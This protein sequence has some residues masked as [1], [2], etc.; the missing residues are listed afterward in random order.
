MAV[1]LPLD[2]S[3]HAGGRLTCRDT[4]MEL[5]SHHRPVPQYRVLFQLIAPWGTQLLA[6]LTLALI[7]A[8]LFLLWPIPYLGYTTDPATNIID[9]IDT[10]STASRAG[11]AVGD[12]ILRRY[13]YD[14]ADTGAQLFRFPL[15]WGRVTGIP[16]VIERDGVVRDLVL[17]V[18]PPTAAY[19]VEKLSAFGVGIIC[20][21]AGCVL[22][23]S[24]RPLPLRLTLVAWFWLA[25]GAI[26]GFYTFASYSSYPLT[27]AAQWLLLTI[28]APVSVYIHVWYPARPVAPATR[29]AAGR[30]LLG[31]LLALQLA[32]AAWLQVVRPPIT[33]LVNDLG[34]I[35]PAALGVA[36][37][38]TGA[39][40]WRVRRATSVRHVRRQIHLIAAACFITASAWLTLRTLPEALAQLPAVPHFLLDLLAGLV[41]LAY[42]A[43]GLLPDLERIERIV[44][45]IARHLLTV[46]LLVVLIAIGG[47]LLA[48]ESGAMALWMAACLVALYRPSH[49][50]V[51]RLAD[52]LA[53]QQQAPDTLGATAMRMAGT[54]DASELAEL[55]VAGVSDAYGGAPAA[56]Y[57]CDPDTSRL[58]L[59]ASRGLELPDH[60]ER[61]A[62]VGRLRGLRAPA[63]HDV[64]DWAQKNI[65][66]ADEQELALHP[67]V[68]LWC[69]LRH[70]ERMLGVLVLGV[71]PDLDPYRANDIAEIQRTLTSAELAFANGASYARRVEAEQSVR[72]LYQRL[73]RAQDE[74]AQ[75]I[76]REL[77]DEIININLRLN[78]AGMERVL[79]QT[80]APEVRDELEQIYGGQQAMST[81]LRVICERLSPVGMDDPLGLPAILEREVQRLIIGWRGVCRLDTVGPHAALAPEVQREA[82]RVAR[83]AIVNAIKHS[84]GTMINIQ[85][86]YPDIPGQDAQL[87]VCDDGIGITHGAPLAGHLGIRNM[88]EGARMV[89]GTLELARAAGGGTEVMFSF[90][91]NT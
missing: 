54:L 91:T 85:L 52:R 6:A 21:L 18:E 41:P 81:M 64:S 83:E 33:A 86:R 77:H 62:L 14:A 75:I 40:L 30:I 42:L 57:R 58:T 8:A 72:R 82:V 9:G 37:V 31:A 88:S 51:Q 7:I 3:V 1:L 23:L 73:Q 50:L 5:S 35:M 70:Q 87:V 56:L 20:W 12:R 69:T 26:A 25:T 2:R 61:G 76:A 46:A 16:L 53:A 15:D 29:I 38:A 74:T 80:H 32:F 19:Q 44:S 24:R 45:A 13:N 67:G 36:F 49:A 78:I 28:F 4:T 22:G 59:C 66:R 10:P 17:P 34:M 89:G 48:L 68:V 43:G 71:R 60:V 63:Q 84:G 11:L 90:P 39:L 65:L 79:N 27:L 47:E 55:L